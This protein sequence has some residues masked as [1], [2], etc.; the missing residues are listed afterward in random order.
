[1]TYY[2]FAVA[3]VLFAVGLYGVVTS[4]SYI[5]LAVCLTV[6]QASTYVLLLAVGYQRGAA[7]PITQGQPPGTQMV[8][9]VVQ[10][11]ALTD[12]VVSVVVLA[13]I[14]SLA[15]QAHR[16]A[17]SVDPERLREMHG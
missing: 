16:R 2:P 14:L 5:H 9:P 1:M 4:R 11:L 15:L 12:I 7:P 8:D 13:L 6:T 3:A 10:A 17:S